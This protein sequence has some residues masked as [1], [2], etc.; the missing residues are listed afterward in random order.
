MEGLVSFRSTVR[1]QRWNWIDSSHG[2]RRRWMDPPLLWCPRNLRIAKQRRSFDRIYWASGFPLIRRE[3]GP[4]RESTTCPTAHIFAC[5]F[6]TNL[7]NLLRK[8]IMEQIGHS[9]SDAHA[10]AHDRSIYP[11]ASFNSILVSWF[12]STFW[13]SC[14]CRR[15]RRW[16]PTVL[17]PS[18]RCAPWLCF[19]TLRVV[20]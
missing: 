7:R 12:N 20:Y 1:T 4:Q 13:F 10:L 18:S 14:S 11:V 6:V 15:A 8:S 2:E 5:S 16:I 3:N 17:C 19:A 9:A